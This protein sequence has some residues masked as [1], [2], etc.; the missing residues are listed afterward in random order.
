MSWLMHLFDATGTNIAGEN[1]LHDSFGASG[2]SDDALQRP[3]LDTDVQSAYTTEFLDGP[4]SDTVGRDTHGQ[5][6][7]RV[8][9]EKTGDAARGTNEN[10]RTYPG[11]R[12]DSRQRSDGGL[13]GQGCELLYQRVF[14]RHDQHGPQ[15]PE[16]HRCGAEAHRH[17]GV[18][19]VRELPG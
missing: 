5:E 7:V 16:P 9:Q 1:I 10:H 3:K 12:P 13:G 8:L 15:N 19:G 2:R 18:R 6:K 11:R 14:V 17:R 4:E